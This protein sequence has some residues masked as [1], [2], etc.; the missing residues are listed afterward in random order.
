LFLALQEVP[1]YKQEQN[2]IL[3]TDLLVNANIV[4]SK[5]QARQLITSK[6]IYVNNKLI[7]SCEQF[8]EK[9]DSINNKF[10]YIRKG[11]KDYFLIIW[12]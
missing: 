8:I 12:G 4:K 1:T 11:K 10:S 9:K 2:K 3:I 5:S 7:E 6:A